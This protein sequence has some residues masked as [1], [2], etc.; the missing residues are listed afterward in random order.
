MNSFLV[1]GTSRLC[2]QYLCFLAWVRMKDIKHAFLCFAVIAYRLWLAFIILAIFQH[3]IN[4]LQ[5]T[6]KSCIIQW[7]NSIT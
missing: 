6:I 4:V 5:C 1:Q 3:A 2:T 7:F